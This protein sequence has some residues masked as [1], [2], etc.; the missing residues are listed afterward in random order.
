MNDRLDIAEE[1]INELE[2]VSS[3]NYSKCEHRKMNSKT[4]KQLEVA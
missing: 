4:E 1:K 3:R 2:G